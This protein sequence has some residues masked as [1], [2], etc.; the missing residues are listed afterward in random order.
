MMNTKEQTKGDAL[1][2]KRRYH[3]WAKSDHCVVCGE[4]Q[5]EG[6]RYCDGDALPEKARDTQLLAWL[7]Q[8]LRKSLPLDQWQR[9]Q[10]INLL[11]SLRALE[12]K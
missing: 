7:E 6:K 1:P 2:E 9:D 8:R 4:E 11:C 3:K 10:L 12:A 5:Y